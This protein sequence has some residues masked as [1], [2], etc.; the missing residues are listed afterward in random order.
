MA[1][2]NTQLSEIKGRSDEELGASLERAREEL[3]KLKLGRTTQQLTNVMQIRHKRREIA[4]I[5]TTIGARRA[6]EQG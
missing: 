5:M 2:R 6:K 1:Q 3:F 4:R